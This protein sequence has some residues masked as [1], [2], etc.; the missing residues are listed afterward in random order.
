MPGGELRRPHL[1]PRC[2]EGWRPRHS[3]DRVHRLVRNRAEGHAVRRTHHEVV[4][5]RTGRQHAG[6]VLPDAEHK[7]I[8]EG[9][10]WGAF[11]NNGQTCAA[12]KRLYVHERIH[13]DVCEHLAAFAKQ[14][15]MGDG[16]NEQSVLGSVQNRMQF[17]KFARL[18]ADAKHKGQVLTGGEPGDGLSFPATIVAG[19]KNGD[20]LVDEEQFGPALPVIRYSDIDEAIR[21]ANDSCIIDAAT[22]PRGR[23]RSPCA[24]AAAGRR[25]IAARAGNATRS[26]LLFGWAVG[27]SRFQA[28]AEIS[29]ESSEKWARLRGLAAGLPAAVPELQHRRSFCGR[30]MTCGPSG[31]RRSQSP[32]ALRASARRPACRRSSF[33]RICCATGSPEV[34]AAVVAPKGSDGWKVHVAIGWGLHFRRERHWVC[35]AAD[36][37]IPRSGGLRLDLRHSERRGERGTRELRVQKAGRREVAMVL[38][39]GF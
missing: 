25:P 7:T 6:I 2:R 32:R 26:A 19:L 27:M 12:M 29:R 11:L 38:H 30:T 15:P 1:Q 9:L 39:I 13:D 22:S 16:K 28:S 37:L 31:G 35:V 23:P 4:H 33:P 14:V 21:A 34:S 5:A 17:D 10:F 3:E 20:A 24:N 18:V 36:G 8:A